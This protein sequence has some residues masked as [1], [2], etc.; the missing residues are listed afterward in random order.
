[1]SPSASPLA[2]C[3]TL[4]FA[5][6]DYVPN[7]SV[8]PGC[9]AAAK[10]ADG[11]EPTLQQCLVDENNARDELDKEWTQYSPALRQRCVATTLSG[12]DHSYVEV[13]VCLR[14]ERDAAQL[15][16]FSTGRGH[17]H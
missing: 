11:L 7:L 13:L 14:M 15:E 6:P 9:R 2:L 4:L 1:M 5:A 8:E 10:M 3:A 12:R 17:G 16:S